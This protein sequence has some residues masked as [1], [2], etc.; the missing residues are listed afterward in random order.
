MHRDTDRH[1]LFSRRVA[2]LGGGKLLLMSALVGR[3]YYLQVVESER[4]KTLADD[5]RINYRLLAPPRGHI[6]DRFGRSMAIN[7]ENHQV[8]LSFEGAKATDIRAT[9]ETLTAMIPLSDGDKRRVLRE[10]RRRRSFVAITLKENLNWEE[11]ARIEVNAPDLPG[12]AI[13]VG[14]TRFYPHGPEVAHVLGYVA[15]VSEKEIDGDPLLELPGFRIGKSGIEKIHDL[16]LRGA[17]GA[18]QVEVDAIGRVMRELERREGQAGAEVSLTIDLELQKMVTRRL[19]DH[20]G[21]VVVMDA[22]NG[23][24]LSMVSSPSFDPNAFNTGLSVQNWQTLIS[25]PRAPLTNKAIAGQY[26]PGS[27]FKMVVALAALERGIITPATQFFCSGSVELGD[28]EFH[29]WKKHGHST[30]DLMKGIS[31]SCDVYFYEIARR[32]GIDRIAAMARRLGFG[33]RLGLDLPGE[34]TGLIPTKRWKRK[35]VGSSWQQGE[36]LIAGI[37]QGYVLATPLQMAVMTA[38][39]VNGG[40]AV[41]PH[42]TRS[43]STLTETST[44]VQEEIASLGIARRH[45]KAVSDAMADVVNGPMGTA[46]KSQIQRSGFEMGGKT[47]T[48][49]V[50]RITKAERD[51]GVRKNEELPWEQRDH[52]LFV[53]YAPLNAPRYVVAV[54]IEHGGGGSKTAA[55]I[56]RDILYEAQVRNAARPG[57]KPKVAGYGSEPA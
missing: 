26:P 21:A 11:V 18:S 37:G 49:Q 48:S 50:R 3:M 29:C 24:V 19:K 55:P 42:L 54:V 52:S 33:G 34:Q 45:L 5:N 30:V 53:G 12:V 16:A 32:V 41:V 22:H 31:Q 43:V 28:A 13:D 23:D 25:N 51:T 15:A 17:G 57:V 36:T 6:I 39:L 44:M 7:Q 35:A 8:V 14:Q 10:M 56:A 38:R 27:T 4:Y 9:L 40:Y 20:S 1:K 2:V 47:G 46:R